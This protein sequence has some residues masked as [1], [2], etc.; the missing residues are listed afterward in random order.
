MLEGAVQEHK[1]EIETGIEAEAKAP[2]ERIKK[3]SAETKAEA[4]NELKAEK[5]A[6]IETIIKELLRIKNSVQL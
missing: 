4:P 5:E 1:V 6:M 2:D 3:E